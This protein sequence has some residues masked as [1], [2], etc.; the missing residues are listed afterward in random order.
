ME[1]G[2]RL[3]TDVVGCLTPSPRI[4]RSQ[5][6]SLV[7]DPIFMHILIKI[8]NQVD[9]G[10]QSHLQFPDD[11]WRLQ[12]LCF[13]SPLPYPRIYRSTH[14]LNIKGKILSSLMGVGVGNNH[15]TIFRRRQLGDSTRDLEDLSILS[16]V[17]FLD[18]LIT[19]HV[20]CWNFV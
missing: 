20:L 10:D 14:T 15:R 4:I 3:R 19:C 13:S 11:W 2:N 12:I 17:Y 6:P 5:N 1:G 7:Q 18:C 9:I 8:I 16:S